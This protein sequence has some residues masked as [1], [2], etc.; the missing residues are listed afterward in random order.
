MKGAIETY[1]QNGEWRNKVEGSRRAANTAATKAAATAKGKLMA[2]Q[3]QVEHIIRN[4]DGE[5]G[6]RNS[7]R[8]GDRVAVPDP[9]TADPGGDPG[10]PRRSLARR[11]AVTGRGSVPALAEIWVITPGGVLA[12]A[13][14]TVA[15]YV[16][17][18]C[19][20]ASWGGAAW[21]R[22]RSATPP[23]SW[24]SARCSAGPPWF[25]AALRQEPVLLMAGPDV[26]HAELPG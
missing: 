3:R 20:C 24:R 9:G 2:Q 18:S 8:P 11:S 14:T 21:P 1:H 23:P 15:M 7:G 19:W 22:C 12:V 25:G 5:I 10:P 26:R 13:L 16:V 6:Q 17:S 4:E